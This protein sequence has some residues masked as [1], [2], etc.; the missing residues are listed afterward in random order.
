[1]IIKNDPADFQNYLSDA[2]NYKGSCE[3][4]L[5]P[6]SENEIIEI[7]KK[8]NL[9]KMQVT[10]SGNRTGLTGAA[11]PEGGIVLSMEKLNKILE[12]NSENYFARI[13]PAVLLDDFQV[14]VEKQNLFYPPDP[15]EK[16]CFVGAT[17][18]TNSSGAKSFKYGATRNYVIG[19]KV[20]LP[21]GGILEIERGKFFAKDYSLNFSSTGGKN[22]SLILPEY[23]MPSVKNA[24]GYYVKKNMDLIDL[25]IGSEGTLG[26]I[27]ELKLKVLK[28][29]E[30]ILS[31]V[32]FFP[33]DKSALNFIQKARDLSYDN[34]KNNLQNL[35]DAL[36]LEFFD[37]GSL[38][39]L[40]SSF[41]EI[42]ESAKAAVWFEQEATESNEESLMEKWVELISEYN[43]DLDNSWFAFNEKEREKLKTFR[44][45]VSW[46]VNEYIAQK[47]F[48]KVGTD[49]AVRDEFVIE[50]FDFIKSNM[51]RLAMPHIIYGHLGNSHF[52]VNMLP[53]NQEQFAIAKS[54]YFDLCKKA[55]EFGGT[56]SAEHGIGKL[57]RPYFELMYDEKDLKTMATLKKFFD[58]NLIL[59][60]GNIISPKY[61][62]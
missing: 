36:G 49:I 37:G 38:S 8:A 61:F 62:D 27:T 43:G 24:A 31:C 55:V 40:S 19:I 32:V 12:I 9:E 21:D 17:A 5:I 20:I 7:I 30:K 14:E 54:L 59:N 29:P 33:D 50:F 3:K 53:E 2:A 58:P 15:T 48:H 35:I 42:P 22:Y 56:V 41:P 51:Q 10:I 26:I 18:A 34:R 45:A 25:F 16:N 46:K 23:S 13:Q 52:H 44:H 6:E 47:G 39:F 1:M 60:F 28:L 4:V 11:V 57:K